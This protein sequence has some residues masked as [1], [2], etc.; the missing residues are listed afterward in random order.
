M[1]SKKIIEAVETTKNYL[2]NEPVV[3][4]YLSIKDKIQKNEDLNSLKREIDSLKDALN[5]AKKGSKEYLDLYKKYYDKKTVYDA[6]PLVQNYHY[7]E[8]RG[9]SLAFRSKGYTRK[10]MI[11]VITG[12]TATHKSETAVRIA[13]KIDA[14]IVNGDAFQVYK[15]LNV[16]VAKPSKEL[17]ETLPHHLYSYVS[18]K[19]EYS[20]YRYQ[21][22]LR[23]K[24]EMLQQANKNVVIVGGSMLYIRAG[25]YDYQL[26]EN[27][28]FDGQYHQQLENMS[29]IELY[30]TLKNVDPLEASKIHLNNRRRLIR[31]LEIYNQNGKTK[32]EI[33]NAQKHEPIYPNVYFFSPSFIKEELYARSDERVDKMFANGLYEEATDLF[34]KYGCNL[35]ALKA[36][37]YKELV[38]VYH[39]K[40]SLEE[41]KN[42]IKLNTRHYIKKQVTFL[43]Y[44][45]KNVNYYK[46]DMDILNVLMKD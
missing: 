29:N 20:I 5:A 26:D 24:I 18:I 13:K 23:A 17:L 44:Q 22:D 21:K 45:F 33:I 40:I 43:K 42:A 28:S 39:N 38:D 10:M 11:V 46:T 27:P 35:K 9:S 1:N 15:E 12:P 14:E 32:S 4:E 8:K 37:G 34:K 31:A 41:A 19:E 7:L 16:G 2:L 6:H 36:I 3:K 25:L 30:E